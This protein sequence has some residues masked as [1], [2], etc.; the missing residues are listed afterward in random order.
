M[1]LVIL[2]LFHLL[3]PRAKIVHVGPTRA[4][5]QYPYQKY[6]PWVYH[7][8]RTGDVLGPRG[9]SIS[10]SNGRPED[11]S[12]EGAGANSGMQKSD[13]L[14]SRPQ[15]FTVTTTNAQDNL[16]HFQGQVPSKHFIL[17]PKG[18]PVFVEGGG[19]PVPWHNGQSKPVYHVITDVVT[20]TH[21]EYR[22]V[23]SLML[24]FISHINAHNIGI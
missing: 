18:A 19:A 3:L 22:L 14:S 21:S 6:G 5:L 24:P 20:E 8:S 11:F 9:C 10:S 13:D 1:Y 7:Q 2:A 12:Q 15:I 17:F 23:M 4:S 16:E